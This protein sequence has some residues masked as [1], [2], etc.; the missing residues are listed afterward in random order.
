MK[1][2]LTAKTVVRFAALCAAI[3][4]MLSAQIY[5]ASI[6]PDVL[7]AIKANYPD[8]LPKYITPEEQQWLD[9]HPE[10]AST[11][12]L[13]IG[14]QTT[15]APSGV[16]WTP[17]E[18]EE[19]DG[20]LIAWENYTDVLTD[21]AVEVSQSDTNAKV[22]VVVDTT[23]ERSSV[24]STL[25]SAGANM[26]NVEFLVRT[27]DTVWI[28]DYGPSYIY[29]DGNPAIIDHIY[30]RPRPYDDDFPV[31]LRTNSVPFVQDEP[32]YEMDLEHGGGNYHVFSNGDAFMTSL[33]LDENT[34]KTESEITA[35]VEDHYNVNL[36]IYDSLSSRVDAT[37]HID[38]WFLPLADDKVIIS[39]FPT[40]HPNSKTITDNAAA[41]MASRGYTVYRTPAYNSNGESSSGGTH[42]TYTNAGIINNKIFIPWYNH[43]TEDAAA[44]ATFQ[45]AMPDHE[46]IQLDCRNVITAA[47]AIHCIIKHVFAAGSTPPEQASNP[48][49]TNGATDISINADVSWTAGSGAT[50]RDV[51]FGTTN[52]PSFIQNQTSTTYDPGTL[53]YNT[54]YYWRIDEKN[55][56]GTTTGTVWSFTTE[57]PDTTPPSPDPLVWAS[58][59]AATGS[60]TITMTATIA[61]DISG[62]EYYFECT[63]DTNASSG[64][65]ASTTYNAGSLNPSTLYTFRVKARDLSPNNNETGFSSEESATTDSGPLESEDFE[66]GLGNWSNVTGDDYDW[67][68]DSGGTPS[69]STGPSSGANGST[70]YMYLETSDGSGAYDE[71]DTAFLEGP[72]LNANA[73]DMNLSFYYHMYGSEMGTLYV[74]VYNGSSW[75]LDIWSISGQQHSSSSDP[76]TQANVDLSSYSGIIKVRFRAV[77]AGGYRGDMAI[78]DIVITG[79]PVSGVTVPDVVGQTQ[80]DAN[81]AII[82][83]GLVVGTITTQCN[84][85]IPAGQVISQDPNAGSSASSGSAVDLVVSTGQPS[86]PDVI[87]M[88]EA[89]A[90]AAINAVADISYGSSTYESSETVPAGDVISQS[91]LGT[92]PC[93]TVVD[94]VVS[95]GPC[96]VD[97]PDMT[98][99]SG[100][101]VQ[102]WLL[103]HPEISYGITTVQCSD[104]MPADH[105]ISQSAI[106]TVPCGTVLDFAMS[107][108]QPSVPDV[109]GMDEA[110]AIAAINAVADI[111]Y[112]SSSTQSSETVPDGDVIS[113]SAVGIVACGTVVDLVVSSG[114]C[115]AVVPD[116]TGMTEAA[117]IAAINAV[118]DISYGS[119]IPQC[120]DTIP[121]E[122]VISQSATGTVPCGTIIDLVVST[123]QPFLP[124][125]SLIDVPEASAIAFIIGMPDISYGMSTTQ[126]SDTVPAGEII[127]TIPPCDNYVPCGT[128]VNLIVSRGQPSVPDVTGLP[129]APARITL[130]EEEDIIYGTTIY[131]CSDTVPVGDVISQSAVGTVP[132]GTV[133]D[134]IVSSGQPIVPNVAG[135][136]EAAAIATINDINDVSYGISTSQCSN[137]VTAGYV[138]SQSAM[139]T[140][141]CGT[142]VD[143]VVSSGQPTV[144]NVAGMSEPAAIAAINAVEDISYGSSYY[145]CSD[146]VGEGDVISQSTTGTVSCGT[147]VDLAVS[148]GQP[149]IS[150]YITE[151]DTNIPVEGVLVDANNG[152]GSDITDADGYYEI[153]VCDWS[154]TVTPSKAGYTFEPTVIEYS[155]VNS[156]QNGNY[157]A[158]LDTF[159]ISGYAVDNTLAPMADVLI[160]PDDDGG[161][162]TS[163][164][165]D[166]G[167][168]ITDVNGYYEVLVDYNWSGNVVPSK[169]AYAFAPDSISYVNVIDDIAEMQD[170]VATLLTYKIEGYIKNACDEPIADIAVDA[171][172]GGSSDTTDANGFYEVW[173]DIE[174]SGTVTPSDDYY[175]FSPA[176]ITYTDVTSDQSEQD[177]EA[178]YIYDLDLDCYIGYGDIS[179]IGDNWLLTGPNIPG[180]FYDD[181][182]VN[183]LDFVEFG[184]AW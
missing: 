78:D 117:A 95:T 144:P 36:T 87:G 132:C 153:A 56:N 11:K 161:T 173:V 23:S 102:Q 135:M 152:G 12:T 54:T 10:I 59:P 85:T 167:S 46:I 105:V 149:V 69:S 55:T 97:I 96:T 91:A 127:E 162:F 72:D 18:Y 68:R 81:T 13:A 119:S 52:P 182:I 140:V 101:E 125:D 123:G 98:G 154:G 34:D 89:S 138:L 181:D 84:D 88:N 159:I 66:T 174:W 142:T 109:T 129:E 51:Y 137:I 21:F 141:A 115:T 131:Q 164:Y 124:C 121:A 25:T 156:N 4:I 62:V 110:S 146:T 133:V 67:T 8:G 3:I 48:D 147:V 20:V 61:T 179:I 30:N 24:T 90:T 120:S 103:S 172:N 29:E 17:G 16:V 157:T 50:S 169:Y 118:A 77:A 1:R 150:G 93:G 122:E 165:Y 32:L 180:D 28:C 139:G 76:Y 38:M 168:D 177:Y 183:F 158:I 57:L 116:V 160:T 73:Y 112:G 65:Q 71:G 27:T 163:K 113:Q 80:A 35:I 2:S 63:T 58:V 79:S 155:N 19:L 41:D 108:G 39:E 40:S 143:L 175:T 53:S 170:Y 6:P 31:W 114:P 26:S 44:L 100:W 60:S 43:S 99:W 9:E 70:W 86:V 166:G 126:C 33:I 94:L 64:W 82:S 47:G 148:L 74:D 106:G 111:S 92:V 178:V 15:A 104:T 14:S 45:A 49:P 176:G 37:G 107:T 145:E 128:V 136:T 184:L 83:A 7:E 22:Y 151:P 5:S 130:V 171:N 134:L 42:Y 75:D